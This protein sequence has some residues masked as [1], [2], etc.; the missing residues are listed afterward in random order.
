MQPVKQDVDTACSVLS[1]D[2]NSN[3]FSSRRTAKMM[4][5]TLCITAPRATIFGFCPDF[6]PHSIHEDMG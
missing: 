5:H 3:S 2:R 1:R 4:L 6:F